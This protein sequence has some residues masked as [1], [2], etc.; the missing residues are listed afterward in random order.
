MGGAG[1]SGLLLLLLLLPPLLLRPASAA[2]CRRRMNTSSPQVSTS[3]G[4]RPLSAARK[5]SMPFKRVAF[6][7]LPS[8]PEVFDTGFKEQHP[9]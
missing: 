9:C 1:V 3:S 4:S 7:S 2:G 6:F 5:P 8:S